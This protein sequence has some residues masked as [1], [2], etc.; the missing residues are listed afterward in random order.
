MK[1][2]LVVAVAAAALSAVGAAAAAREQQTLMCN[3]EPL[4]LTVTTTNNDHSVDWGVGTISG[5]S[6]LIP[7]S[8]TFQAVDVSAGGML[9]GSSTQAKGD[10]NGMHNQQA[11]TCSQSQTTTAGAL[12]IPDL[13]SSDVIDLSFVVTAVPKG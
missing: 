12:G 4:A 13:P 5:G 7:T 10:G 9:L 3:G 1:R 8:F 2:I 6:H 11:I